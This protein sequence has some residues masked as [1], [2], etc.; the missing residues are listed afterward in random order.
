MLFMISINCDECNK[1][2]CQN[3]HLTPILLPY[4]EKRFKN[5]SRK[6]K[7]PFRDMFVLIKKNNGPCIFLDDKTKKC[8]TYQKRPLECTLYPFLLD[9]EKTKATVKLDKRFCP[10]IK[11]LKFDKEKIIAFLNKNEF[12]S[13]WI[14]GYLA[15]EDY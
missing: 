4:E 1:N 14:K 10:H 8:T 7:T 5:Y 2:C 3:P 15:L 9:F 12:P 11:T 13:N 6:I